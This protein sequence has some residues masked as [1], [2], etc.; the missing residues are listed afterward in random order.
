M[1]AFFSNYTFVEKRTIEKK[2]ITPKLPFSSAF[3]W[4]ANME[5][6]LHPWNS[7]GSAITFGEGCGVG[8]GNPYGC[9]DNPG[10]W[11]SWNEDVGA[12][13][14]LGYGKK[15]SKQIN[16]DKDVVDTQGDDLPLK[17]TKKEHS[18]V[19]VIWVP[20]GCE[21]PQLLLFG[22]QVLTTEVAMLTGFVDQWKRV[23]SGWSMSN[24]S[25]MDT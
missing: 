1:G 15:D 14:E 20:P 19:M 6:Y 25:E 18:K 11:Q 9:I 21:E 4:N 23:K 8:G 3:G 16:G 5:W 24:A 22:Q 2:Y 13:V 12:V 17:N 7:P 10:P